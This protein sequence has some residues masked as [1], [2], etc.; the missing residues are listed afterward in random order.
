MWWRLGVSH[1]V[2]FSAAIALMGLAS[3]S[4]GGFLSYQTH[5][6]H[7]R[8]RYIPAS[9]EW[10][11][12]LQDLITTGEAVSGGE[13]ATASGAAYLVDVSGAVAQPGVYTIS[14][15]SRLQ[16]AILMAGGFRPE[17]D[18][19]FIHQEMNLASRLHDQQ[20]IYVPLEG[21]H[22]PVS[23]DSN[24]SQ[25]PGGNDPDTSGKL[26]LG[27]ATA[28]QL[29]AL[30]GIGEKRAAS[31]LAGYP[32]AS[33]ADFLER[34]GLSQNLAQELLESSLSLE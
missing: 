3:F 5:F 32:Y 12:Y 18:Q 16:D 7:P 2:A 19:R 24:H 17:A 28:K 1:D 6:K 30:E 29:E 20:K 31:I 10:R 15:E 11:T 23:V 25:L 22:I 8:Y 21:E 26:S 4:V 9:E 14:E 33:E 34:S 13:S 27:T